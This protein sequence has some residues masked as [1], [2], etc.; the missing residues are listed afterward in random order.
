MKGRGWEWKRDARPAVCKHL[1][2]SVRRATAHRGVTPAALLLHLMRNT[3][4]ALISHWAYFIYVS[5]QQ[6]HLEPLVVRMRPGARPPPAAAP[7]RDAARS[8]LC[9][10]LLVFLHCV[11]E[12]AV[13]EGGVYD[14]EWLFLGAMTE[15]LGFNTSWK[16]LHWTVFSFLKCKAHVFVGHA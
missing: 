12:A 9:L 14:G 10:C 8:S 11:A 7:P 2:Q 1:S 4:A 5:V 6:I 16:A 13:S 15:K 3:R